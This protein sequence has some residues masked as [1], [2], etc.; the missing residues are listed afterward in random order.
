MTVAFYVYGAHRPKQKRSE[1]V[2]KIKKRLT[3]DASA[4]I[5]QR[6]ADLAVAAAREVISSIVQGS[7][8]AIFALSEAM[9]SHDMNGPKNEQQ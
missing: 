1:S 7:R 4:L 6:V 8:M 3:V 9:F 5:D 2:I